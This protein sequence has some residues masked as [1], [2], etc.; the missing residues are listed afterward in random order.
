MH[1]NMNESYAEWK[2]PD[3]NDTHCKIQIIYN[4]IKQTSGSLRAGTEPKEDTDEVG[5]RDE[6]L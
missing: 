5:R 2:K 3:T 1:L 4:D 6:V